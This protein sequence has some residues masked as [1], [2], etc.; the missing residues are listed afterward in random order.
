MAFTSYIF[1]NCVSAGLTGTYHP[2]LLGVLASKTVAF[3]AVEILL[4][5][6]GTY[7][8]EC[9]Q[10][11]GFRGLQWVQ[12]RWDNLYYFVGVIFSSSKIK[13]GVFLYTATSNSF[14]EIF[15]LYSST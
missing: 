11:A 9:R 5:K 10:L 6:L 3:I 4:L 15:A 2:Q 12:I 14:T 1:I 7:L 8:L 13:W